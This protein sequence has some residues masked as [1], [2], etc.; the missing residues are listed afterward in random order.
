MSKDAFMDICNQVKPLISKQDMKY[1][2]AIPIEISVSC[3]IYKREQ[4]AN[5]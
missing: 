3:A 1:K 4:G 5:I 2:K